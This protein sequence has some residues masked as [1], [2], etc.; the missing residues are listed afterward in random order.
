MLTDRQKIDYAKSYL[1]RT[2]ICDPLNPRNITDLKALE[3]TVYSSVTGAQ[4]TLTA[5]SFEGGSQ[6]GQIT[7][8]ASVLGFAIKELL[9]KYDPNYLPPY[10]SR[11]VNPDWSSCS[12]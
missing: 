10:E 11:V 7:F 4:I 2:Y 12:P 6:S 9:E 8:E 5:T 3:Q 1:Y